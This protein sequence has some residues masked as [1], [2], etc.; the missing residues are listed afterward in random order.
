MTRLC[1]VAALADDLGSLRQFCID[2]L[3]RPA[4]IEQ[5][6]QNVSALCPL[7]G[8]HVRVPGDQLFVCR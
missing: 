6:S 5:S 3:V 1:S 4:F 8:V 7:F 2:P